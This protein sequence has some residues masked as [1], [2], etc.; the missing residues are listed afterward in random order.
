M[1][2]P[3]TIGIPD[4]NEKAVSF[5]ALHERPGCFVMPN[6]WDA[7]SATLLE[8]MGFE[9]LGTTSAGAA[10]SRARSDGRGVLSGDETL[11]NARA[12]LEATRLPVSGDLENGWDPRPEG[13]ADAIRRAAAAGLVGASIEDASG[14][15]DAPIYEFGLA[16]DRMRAAAQAKRELGFP[17]VLTGRAENL[18]HGRDDLADTIR[19]L[20]AFQ[21]AGADV[22]YAPGLSTKGEI[23]SV[24][25]SVDRPVNVLMGLGGLEASVA[26][27]SD[28][29]VSRI[30]LGSSLARA[31]LGALHDAA[32]EV[33]EKGTFSFASLAM[34][35][36]DLNQLFSV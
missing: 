29:G 8:S 11:T 25:A 10:F 18:L 15:L 32:R 3:Q 21:E 22:L 14:D 1:S 35:Y 17:F 24:L 5:S 2:V 6:P 27:L 7:G 19:R 23:A 16:I 26:E 31:A 34:P 20:Q 9:A 33:H 36:A 12:I 13:V 28:L 4:Q 30:S